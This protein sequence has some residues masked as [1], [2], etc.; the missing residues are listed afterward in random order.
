MN[1]IGLFF[2]FMLVGVKMHSQRVFFCDST[3]LVESKTY[4]SNCAYFYNLTEMRIDSLIYLMPEKQN[5]TLKPF[6][7]IA[8]TNLERKIE[9]LVFGMINNDTIFTVEYQ[10][11]L[12][13]GLFICFEDNDTLSVTSMRFG[14]KNGLQTYKSSRKPTAY[15]K[16]MFTNGIPSGPL[17]ETQDGK[18]TYFCN[19]K[20]GVKHGAEYQFYESGELAWCRVNESGNVVDGKYVRFNIEGDVVEEMMFKNGKLKKSI[21]Y[22]NGKREKVIKFGNY[23]HLHAR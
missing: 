16:Q 17:V 14:K 15:L 8:P 6:K 1:K 18:L 5:F 3:Y 20:N 7:V 11:G 9:G 2:L 19:F 23:T 21:R 13:H 4:E 12:A 10:N 22:I